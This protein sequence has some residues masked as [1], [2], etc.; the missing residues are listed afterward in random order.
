M[1]ASTTAS[2]SQASETWPVTVTCTGGQWV[3]TCASPRCGQ[4]HTLV[5][6]LTRFCAEQAAD[7][8]LK[9]LA[10]SN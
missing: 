9:Y 3:A 2:T 8:H 5:R 1:T 7:R 6:A 10:R 4:P